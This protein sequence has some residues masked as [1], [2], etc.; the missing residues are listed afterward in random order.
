MV[1][2]NVF[3]F[4]V[5]VRGFHYYQKIWQPMEEKLNWFQEPKNA[6]DAYV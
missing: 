1:N 4:T 5:A 3:E 6:F 2:W